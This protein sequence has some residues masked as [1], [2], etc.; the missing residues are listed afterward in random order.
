V[1]ICT[2]MRLL[3]DFNVDAP[4]FVSPVVSRPSAHRPSP[5][6]AVSHESSPVGSSFLWDRCHCTSRGSPDISSS[7]ETLAPTDHRTG[8]LDFEMI[9]LFPSSSR[10]HL[11]SS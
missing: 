4:S 2:A 6:C 11:D 10:L 5:S 9:G 1:F 8:S 7:L 3:F